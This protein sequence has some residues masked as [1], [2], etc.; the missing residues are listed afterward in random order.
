M[1]FQV[2]LYDYLDTGLFL[3]HR[4]LR[5]IIKDLDKHRM[6]LTQVSFAT[7]KLSLQIFRL[8]KS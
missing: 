1:K 7:P 5:K 6:A 8:V 4:P 3:D 2:N